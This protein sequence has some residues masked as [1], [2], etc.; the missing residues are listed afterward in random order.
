MLK[1]SE[2]PIAMTLGDRSP[3]ALSTARSVSGSR[4]TMLA[5]ASCPSLVRTSIDPPFAA[6]EITWSF[7]RMWPSA[8]MISPEPLPRSDL[9]W[10]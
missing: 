3:D 9:C 4:P 2:E 10:R 6:A 7:V 5:A 1:P 8:L